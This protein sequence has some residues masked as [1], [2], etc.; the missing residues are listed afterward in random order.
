MP[1]K[2]RISSQK[3]TIQILDTFC[4]AGGSSTGAVFA[5]EELGHRPALTCVNHNK[6]AIATHTVNHPGARHYCTGVD[7]LSLDS[8]YGDTLLDVLWSSPS[9]VHHS[10]AR[11]GAPINDQER[12]T[13]WCV[14]RIAETLKP[15]VIL[16]ENVGAFLSWGPSE[17]KWSKKLGTW[18]LHPDPKRK[19]ET[20]QAWLEALRSL[21]YKVDWKILCCAD[22]GDPTTRERLFIQC[23]GG[24]RKI[25]WPNQTHI[26]PE[27]LTQFQDDLFCDGTTP[28][29]WVPARDIIDWTLEGASI[30]EREKSLVEKTLRR[31]FMGLDRIGLKKF[32]EN[33]GD[34][35]LVRQMG[36]STAEN[37]D[38]PLSAVIGGPKHYVA[39]PFFAKLRGTSTTANVNRPAPAVTGGGTHLGLVEASIDA[40]L[41]QQSEGLLREINDPTPTVSTAGAISFIQAKATRI[42]NDFLVQIAHGNKAGEGDGDSRRIKG[43]ENPLG[44]ITGSNEFGVAEPILVQLN[45]VDQN[46]NGSSRIKGTDATMG[47]VCGNRGEWSLCES[48]LIPN[49]G[50]RENQQPRSHEIDKPLPAVTGHGAGCLI[51]AKARKAGKEKGTPCVDPR[52]KDCVERVLASLTLTNFAFKGEWHPTG[53][54]I[55]LIHGERYVLEIL[56]RMLQPHELAAA[57]GFPKNYQFQGTKTEVIKQIG[58]AVPCNTARALVK[59]VLTQNP[60]VGAPKYDWILSENSLTYAIME[61]HGKAPTP[62]AA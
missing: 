34:K 38:A 37:L 24:K 45:H 27:K 18:T 14:V 1:P 2:N 41:P 58:N 59:A 54:P 39:E 51:Q 35:F 40:L 12:A 46:E 28:L 60:E 10:N 26:N 61:A 30:F 29:P 16:I 50:E 42:E 32:Q 23:V 6:M 19:G 21:G 11:G 44:T 3:T 57:Q 43:L 33:E 4:G 8:M 7:D 52:I 53:R 22:Y 62:V 55:I 36:Q 9:C 25:V 17:R 5:I 20:F 47:T 15:P 49:F 56:F 48:Y 13:G 31:I